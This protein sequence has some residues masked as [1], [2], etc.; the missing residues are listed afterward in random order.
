[1]MLLELLLLLFLA[2]PCHLLFLI[3]YTLPTNAAGVPYELVIR[4]PASKKSRLDP[5]PVIVFDSRATHLFFKI[6]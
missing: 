2:L 3:G 5:T 6:P 4:S 1:M